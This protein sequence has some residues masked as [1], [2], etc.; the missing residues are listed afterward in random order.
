MTT[1]TTPS[2]ERAHQDDKAAEA[3]ALFRPE[4]ALD[5]SIP[6]LAAEG[7]VI[8]TRYVGIWAY[9]NM[10]GSGSS[11]TPMSIAEALDIE[12]SFAKDAFDHFMDVGCAVDDGQSWFLT[13]MPFRAYQ[14]GVTDI[15][16]I[17]QAAIR[18]RQREA[19]REAAFRASLK[20]PVAAMPDEPR[21]DVYLYVIGASND[22]RLKI[23]ISKNVPNRLKALQSNS[24]A[25]LEVHWTARANYEIEQQLHEKF[26]KY[27][28]HGEWFDFGSSTNPVT[29]I[30]R[31]ALRLGAVEVS[32]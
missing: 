20:K 17:R 24:P 27:R 1:D 10:P 16:V 7:K 32:G 22:S 2:P 28:S 12:L 21:L 3:L 23:G 13:E 29:R 19:E 30:R 4:G 31:E 18:H 5:T 8:D 26:H 11:H 6:I 14:A 25:P 9:I 15:E